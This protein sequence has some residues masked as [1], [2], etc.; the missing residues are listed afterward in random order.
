MMI[1]NKYILLLTTLFAIASCNGQKKPVTIVPEPVFMETDSSVSSDGIKSFNRDDYFLVKGDVK[2][3]AELKKAIDAFV[4]KNAQ[5]EFKKNYDYL[6]MFYVETPYLNEQ[7]VKNQKVGYQY[8]IFQYN[9]DDDFICSYYFSRAELIG[10][11]WGDQF[12]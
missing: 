6:M 9:K 4:T 5:K 3:K 12:K 11:T 1:K 2:D 7:T 10:V 8:K